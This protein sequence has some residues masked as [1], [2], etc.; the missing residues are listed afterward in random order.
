MRNI[1]RII[2]LFLT[3]LITSNAVFAAQMSV[4]MTGDASMSV[5]G[6]MLPCHSEARSDTETHA[7]DAQDC[8]NG[9]CNSCVSGVITI[10]AVQTSTCLPSS[11]VK[12]GVST[13]NVLLAYNVN[14]FRPPILI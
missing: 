12:V 13:E 4:S 1:K 2:A 14:L 7:E 3:L 9:D 8:C 5:A 10:T 11:P 6:T